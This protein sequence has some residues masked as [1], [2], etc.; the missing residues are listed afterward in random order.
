M[1]RFDGYLR[2]D[3]RFDLW[4]YSVRDESF[5]VWDRHNQVFAYGPSSRISNKHHHPKQSFGCLRP[6]RIRKN[7]YSI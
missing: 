2:A 1:A 5:I 3:G 6:Q 4:G 7:I